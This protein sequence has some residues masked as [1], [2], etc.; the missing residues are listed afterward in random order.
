[1]CP[2]G[3]SHHAMLHIAWW[4]EPSGH[5]TSDLKD[6]TTKAKEAR[7][8]ARS[9]ASSAGVSVADVELHE[10]GLARRA[11]SKRFSL[12]RSNTHD[13]DGF[14]SY[15]LKRARGSDANLAAP[16][17]RSFLRLRVLRAPVVLR[18]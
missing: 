12:P 8:K 2:L 4:L 1:M 10:R 11:S 5:M 14:Q 3:S 15:V 16:R 9:H 7:A 18:V 6:P 17:V 13:R